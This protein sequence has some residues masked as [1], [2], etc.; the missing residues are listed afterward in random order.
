VGKEIGL[1]E[2]FILL[3]KFKD[4]NATLDRHMRVGYGIKY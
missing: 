4:K 3:M 2:N 1:Q